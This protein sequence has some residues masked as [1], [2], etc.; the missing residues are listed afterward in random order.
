MNSPKDNLWNWLDS[1]SI[2]YKNYEIKNAIIVHK[3]GQYEQLMQNGNH[4]N[5]RRFLSSIKWELKLNLLTNKMSKHNMILKGNCDSLNDLSN[6]NL[7]AIN[8]SPNDPRTFLHISPLAKRDKRSLVITVRDD[9][10][11]YFNEIE[12]PVILLNISNPWRNE[13]D[14]KMNLSLTSLENKLPLSLD[15]IS[16]VLFSKS[17]SL[18][19]LLD[20]I[21]NENGLPQTHLEG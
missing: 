1:V 9:V 12:I 19:D 3:Y 21:T 4:F 6:K 13:N 10:Y 8:F 7:Y 15:L 14:L 16:L 5:L 11:N 2:K 20:I 18:I 17:A